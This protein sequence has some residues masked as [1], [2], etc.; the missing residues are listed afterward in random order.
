MHI[1]SLIGQP[2]QG[3][4][5]LQTPAYVYKKRVKFTILQSQHQTTCPLVSPT[6]PSIAAFINPMK[7]QSCSQ[8]ICITLFMCFP[9][10]GLGQRPISPGT[11]HTPFS[12]IKL[13]ADPPGLGDRG[14]LSDGEN[15]RR[16]GTFIVYRS[17]QMEHFIRIPQN[18]RSI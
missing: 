9:D 3:T 10:P 13:I 8:S 16:D 4:F 6:N 11:P 17:D 7:V 5:L 1:S 18:M 12:F 14:Y 2:P 15:D